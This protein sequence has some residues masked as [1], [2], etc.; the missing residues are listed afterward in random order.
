MGK[1]ELSFI[2]RDD[3]FRTVSSHIKRI[4]S[5][6]N[7][8][9]LVI[10]MARK[11][12]CFYEA[13]EK[14]G[15]VNNTNCKIVSSRI[16]YYNALSKY[17]DK[18][19][20]VIDDVVVR[21]RSI[22]RVAATLKAEKIKADYY[23]AACEKNFLSDFE[24]ENSVKILTYVTY[25]RSEIYHFSGLITQYIEASMRTFNVDSPVY[26]I[27]N[28]IDDMNYKLQSLGAVTLTSGIQAQSGIKSR[29]LYFRYE[30]DSNVESSINRVLKESIIKIRFY[31]NE[32]KTIA[33]PFVLLPE[34][35]FSV[36]EEL[37]NIIK[38]PELDDFITYG[39]DRRVR[40]NKY[41]LVSYFLS[42]ALFHKF[43]LDTDL[44]Y[45]R[46]IINDIIQFDK[47]LGS[48]RFLWD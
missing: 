48:S 9:D 37:Y 3:Y 20:A 7:E 27:T 8:Y 45:S 21:G 1:V 33:V 30:Y 25:S 28:T 46:D 5:V 2:F 10:F 13:L 17:R 22:N 47:D 14:N 12:I 40:E 23:V 4:Q 34:C 6:L 15:E 41:K 29:S 11:A 43:A 26:E 31:N 42:D 44:Y 39:N 19:I 36:L 35:D 18:K 38:N 24:H 16:V 32:N